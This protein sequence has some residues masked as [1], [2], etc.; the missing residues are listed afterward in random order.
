MSD[1]TRVFDGSTLGIDGLAD[2]PIYLAMT[3]AATPIFHAMTVART[4]G[5]RAQ[6]A[7]S[8]PHTGRHQA[9]AAESFDDCTSMTLPLPVQSRGPRRSA[10][11]AGHDRADRRPVPA[12]PP[13]TWRS[14]PWVGASAGSTAAPLGSRLPD[15]GASW[16]SQPLAFVA[17]PESLTPTSRGPGQ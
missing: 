6:P 12:S 10:P 11:A 16:S 2:T 15:P 8:V 1:P 17:C 13:P 7:R 14:V 3:A 4:G 5:H 9:T